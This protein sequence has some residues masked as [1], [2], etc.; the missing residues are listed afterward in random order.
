MNIVQKPG[1]SCSKLMMLLVNNL[2][3]FQMAILQIHCYFL[4]IKCE[5]P[6]QYKYTVI[7][8]R[9]NVR[10]LCIAKDSHILSTKNNSVFAYVVGIYLTS[11]GLND[12]VKI[13]KF[14]TTG[15]CCFFFFFF[16]LSVF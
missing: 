8:C 15:P 7:F 12:D 16:F 6:L 5:N 1:A 9:K 4:L 10:I 3:K 11:S 13:T 14:C 2:L